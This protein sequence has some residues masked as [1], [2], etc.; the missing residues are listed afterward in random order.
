MAVRTTRCPIA[1]RESLVFVRD[2]FFC[3]IQKSKHQSGISVLDKM[4]D[5]S[6]ILKGNF[7][8]KPRGLLDFQ[9]MQTY[10]RG[11]CFR[12]LIY[13][14]HCMLLPVLVRYL[15]SPLPCFRS[16]FRPLCSAFNS[17]LSFVA[18]FSCGLKRYGST[19]L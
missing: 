17:M 7:A 3:N 12:Q 2:Q 16:D 18:V 19:E 11:H 14:A 9:V 4:F 5:L 15:H 10:N 6:S 8:Q 1:D 13:Q